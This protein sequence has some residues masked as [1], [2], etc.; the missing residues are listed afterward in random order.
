MKTESRLI[1][2]TER[3]I[4]LEIK[5]WREP[6]VPGARLESNPQQPS[7]PFFA[8]ARVNTHLTG[9]SRTRPNLILLVALEL[10]RSG[11][12]K[13]ARHPTGSEPNHCGS[14]ALGRRDL[15]G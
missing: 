11:S 10:V 4:S 15:A 8:I 5:Q 7:V 3:L 14:T 6:V 9:R 2:P 12:H 1:E 13:T